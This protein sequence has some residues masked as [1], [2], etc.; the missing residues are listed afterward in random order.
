MVGSVFSAAPTVSRLSPPGGQRGSKVVTTCTGEFSWPVKVWA[1]GV[2]VAVGKEKGQLEITIPKD[3]PADRIWVRLFNDEGSSTPFP[4][5]VGGLEEI[6]EEEPN[7][8]RHDAQDISVSAVTINGVLAQGGDV[9][10]FAV[11]LEANQTLVA[12]VDANTRLGSPMDSILQVVSA[13][14]IVLGENHDD[15]GLDSRLAFTAKES[16]TYIVRL[17]AFPAAPGT[18]IAFD[19]SENNVYRLS[20]TTQPYI[21]HSVPL[22]VPQSELGT[23]EVDGW[24]VPPNTK[25]AVVPFG[26]APLEGYREFEP[27][28]DLRISPD[29]RLGFI[30]ST[31]FNGA[32]RVRMV[33][34]AVVSEIVPSDSKQPTL[35]VPPVAVTGR[36]GEPGQIDS[37]QVNLNKGQQAIISVESQTLGLPVI[38]ELQLFDP[39]GKRIAEAKEPGI[40]RNNA[41]IHVA[42]VDGKYRLTI[43]DQF[44]HGSRRHFYGL[45]VRLEESDFELSANADAVVVAAEEP[46]E[47]PI[48]IQRWKGADKVPGPITI[49]VIGLPPGITAP[50]VVSEPTG[51]S[52]GKVNL[53]FQSDGQAFSGPIRVVGK[54]S[55]PQEIQRTARTPEKFSVR[56]DSIW[57]TAVAKQQ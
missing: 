43:R 10:G 51:D 57:M 19:G 8:T 5:L 37:F 7:N 46:T 33:P 4:F 29:T 39:S 40:P 17:F 53:V 18:K 34:Y 22:S 21:T 50:A 9:D 41:M 42:D 15:I 52:A 38:P 11:S 56:F 36:L 23:I 16:G 25:L 3:L 28:N 27:S 13:D 30:F 54:A 45:T 6:N 26:G 12:V 48:T 47:F 55:D 20:I 32:A 24:N 2:E 31:Q 35:L 14:G 44:G 1:P 49:E